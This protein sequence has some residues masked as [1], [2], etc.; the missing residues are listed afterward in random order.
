MKI[1]V[2][3]STGCCGCFAL[4]LILPLK[5]PLSTSSCT[6]F[7]LSALTSLLGIFAPSFLPW[8][9]ASR[10]ILFW[11]LFCFSTLLQ[12]ILCE[13][14]R[15][16]SCSIHMH[17]PSNSNQVLYWFGLSQMQGRHLWDFLI[18]PYFPCSCPF[19]VFLLSFLILFVDG[20]ERVKKILLFVLYTWQHF[21]S[22]LWFPGCLSQFFS[23]SRNKENALG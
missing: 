20:S 7:I 5:I 12:V 2:S 19:A 15:A 4:K 13:R 1:T 16:F 11:L 6:E 10:Y 9:L 14:E 21:G 18:C 3:S 8:C 23:Q 22:L 17:T